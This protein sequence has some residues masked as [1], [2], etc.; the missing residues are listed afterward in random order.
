MVVATGGKPLPYF[1]LFSIPLPVAE[2]RENPEVWE[3]VHEVVWIVVAVLIAV[4]VLGALFNHF[5]A[6]NDVL[7]RMTIGIR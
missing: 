7:R 2:N 4:H 6:K 3:G 1:G 5:I